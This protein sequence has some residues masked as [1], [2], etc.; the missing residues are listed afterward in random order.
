MEEKEVKVEDTTI[1]TVKE[2]A[3]SELNEIFDDESVKALS[4][5]NKKA[6]ATELSETVKKIRDREDSFLPDDVADEFSDSLDAW[7]ETHTIEDIDALTKEGLKEIFTHGDDEIEFSLDFKNEDESIKFK[8]DYL[9]YRKESYDAI[10]KFDKEIEKL[11]EEYKE[12]EKELDSYI[13]QFGSINGLIRSR[14]V[15]MIENSADEN[16]EKFEK[17]LEYYDYGFSLEN[18][19]QYA[20]S[21]R[22][23]NIYSDYKFDKNSHKI[24][25]KYLKVCETLKITTD[26]T[27]YPDLEERCLEG[28]YSHT[29]NLFLFSII[30]YIASLYNKTDEL[31][32]GLFLSQLSINVK[33]LLFDKFD[34]DE[35][36]HEFIK[37]VVEILDILY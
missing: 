5:L 31:Y 17:Y 25:N 6:Q 26:L 1:D 30:H 8:K 15:H 16:K 34:N 35:D 7:C 21:F 37:N 10:V 29:P 32:Y 36:K 18:I 33:N 12:A 20:R 27:K 14:L 23:K 22:G 24:Y 9:K 13:K 4:V 28:D 2:K 11:E 19:K 3:D